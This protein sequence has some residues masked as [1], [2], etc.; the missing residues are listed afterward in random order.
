MLKQKIIKI[1][2]FLIF[3]GIFTFSFYYCFQAKADENEESD[4]Y[5]F[6]NQDTIWRKGDNLIFNK[7]VY[8]N[9]VTITIEPGAEIK[10]GKN[11]NGEPT[12]LYLTGGRIIAEGTQKEPIIF[13]T[14][15][16]DDYF[17]IEFLNNYY[18]NGV[19]PDPPSFFRYVEIS[20]AGGSQD[21]GGGQQTFNRFNLINKAYAFYDYGLPAFLFKGGKAHFENCRFY[22]NKGADVALNINAQSEKQDD[23]LEIVNSNFEKNIENKAVIS[24]LSGTAKDKNS[25]RV[26][27]KNNWYD[28]ELG[29]K[30]A[31]NYMI[32]G[33]IIDGYYDLAGFRS[34]GLI[35]DPVVIIPGIMGSVAEYSGMAGEL[36]L[37]PILHTY[38]NLVFSF[39]RN[40]YIK[41]INLFEFPYEWRNS[42]AITSGK[43]KDQIKSIRDNMDVSRVDLVAHS[44][45]G[46]VARSYIEGLDYQNDV[47]QLVTLGTPQKG[48]PDAY[49]KWEAGEGFE[50]ISEKVA[51]KYFQLE[52]YHSNP[53]YNDLGKYIREKVKSVG[54]L[55][56]DYDYLQEVSSGNMK[57]YPHDYPENSFLDSLNSQAN[58]SNLSKVNFCNIIGNINNSERTIKK[59]RV[60]DSDVSG[61]WEHG[62]PE[63]FYD[64]STDRGIEYGQGDETVPFSSADGILANKKIV[65]D[66]S[67]GDLPTVAQCE[68]FKELTGKTNCQYVSDFDR[69]KKVITFGVFSPIDIQVVD[70][71][72]NWAG[73]NI[74]GLDTAKKIS[75]AFYSGYD[76]PNEFVTIPDPV[77]GEYRIITQGTGTGGEYKIETASISEDVATSET[78]ESSAEITGMAVAGQLEEKSVTLENNVVTTEDKDV[79]PPSISIVFP[80]NGKSYLNSKIIDIKFSATDN[81]TASDKIKI[82]LFLDGNKLEK[83]SID[84]ALQ[85]LGQHKVEITAR[86]E[87]GNYLENE[88]EFTNIASIDSIIS[89]INHYRDLNLILKDSD[90]KLLLAQMNIMDSYYDLLNAVKNDRKMNVRTKTVLI[91]TIGSLINLEVNLIVSQLKNKNSYKSVDQGVKT[92]LI[93]DINSLKILN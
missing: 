63:S 49:L 10:F 19:S 9:G 36:K 48:S 22:E 61:S 25:I 3:L 66:S 42:N 93:E 2:S 88:I 79:N 76:N 24:N 7:D 64:S 27:L 38:D 43:L 8:I 40:G 77:D 39:E 41:D 80:E 65:L 81:K 56:P 74:G 17:H 15:S 70:K 51:K 1:V 31:P 47:D 37:D 62:M 60:I 57:I 12:G 23:Y 14:A 72:G 6:I 20:R 28:N 16:A 18:E 26:L 75:G 84:L 90:R 86:D 54:E 35:A 30:V 68:V 69:I 91:K 33:E 92:L 32:G 87:A 78:Q 13:T 5:L 29:P 73:K 21:S 55:L 71:D 34:S 67:H 58:L 89:N 59:F 83:S 44:M 50:D 45:G 82:E 46:L 52:A 53:S 4:T 11:I 85:S